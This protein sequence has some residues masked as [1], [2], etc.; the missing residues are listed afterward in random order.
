MFHKKCHLV[1]LR[2]LYLTALFEFVELCFSPLN[3]LQSSVQSHL[4]CTVGTGCLLVGLLHAFQ[5]LECIDKGKKHI[6]QIVFSDVD[7]P[8]QYFAVCLKSR[9]FKP[10][11]NAFNLKLPKHEILLLSL[12]WD[13]S[14]FFHPTIY[15]I[16]IWFIGLY[17]CSLS[18]FSFHVPIVRGRESSKDICPSLQCALVSEQLWC[19]L[20]L[21]TED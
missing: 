4:C 15:P 6:M 11:I 7:V 9:I 8:I 13:D 20:T 17:C 21:H 14:D 2:W 18:L 5:L 16:L 10:E 1:Y 3:L 19:S 12:K